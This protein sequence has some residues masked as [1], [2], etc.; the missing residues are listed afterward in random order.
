MAVLVNKQTKIM[1]QGITGTQASFHVQRA[2]NYGTKIVAGV[3]PNKKDSTHLG[4]PLF[5]T[6]KEAKE[7]TGANASIVF[8]PAKFAK[9]AILEAIDAEL[10]LV[11]VITSGIPVNDMMEIKQRLNKSQTVLIGPNTPGV[12][13]PDEAYM[14]IFPDNIH[15][16]G[17]IGIVS[18]S[19]T[20]TYEVILEINAV[21]YGES[22]IVGLGDDFILGSGFIDIIEKFNKD[23]K[24][25]AIV[26]IGGIG[27][28]YE[29]EIA[30]LYKKM[31]KKKPVIALIIDDKA[32]LSNVDGIA[33]EIICRGVTT[34]DEKKKFLSES[35]MTVVD[36]ISMLKE[37]LN[38]L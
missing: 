14:G 37:E 26:L 7:N 29:L 25:K 18:R 4:L 34:I 11:V 8:V 13:T 27:G 16:A 28:N 19:S 5:S 17:D 30:D 1:V 38:K 33:H 10:E 31:K 20:L 36:N 9:S 15:K 3:V 32:S 35:G 22:T 23:K 6:V 21:G 24:T 12:I 2:L